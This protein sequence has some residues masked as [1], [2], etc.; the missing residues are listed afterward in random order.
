[1][2]IRHTVS[3][4][5]ILLAAVL[6]AVLLSSCTDDGRETGSENMV[7]LYRDTVAYDHTGQFVSIK[8]SVD[9]SISLGYDGTEAG[10]AEVS[11]DEGSGDRNNVML[12]YSENMD[13]VSR[14]VSLNVAFSDG[15]QITVTLVQSGSPG[16]PG[17]DSGSGSEPDP[18]RDLES[19]P[20]QSGWMELP[21]VVENDDCTFYSH[22]MTVSGRTVRNYSFLYDRDNLLSHW[23]AYPLNSGL[24]GS[25]GRTGEWGYDPLVPRNEQPVLFSGYRGNYDRGHQQPSADRLNYNANVQTFY[26]TNMTPQF[27]RNFNQSIWAGL[28]DQVRNVA[29]S[30]DTLYVV[31]G[32][33][34]DGSLGVA[35]DNEGKEVTVPGAYFKALLRYSASSGT[36]YGGYAAA[37]F[38]LE[39]RSYGSTVITEDM[40]KSIDELEE[41]T[42]LDFFVNLPDK[43]GPTLAAQVEAQN[44]DNVGIWWN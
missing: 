3:R 17:D 34:L 27:G 36:G 6:P 16:V 21:A 10:W 15:E 24:I 44:P 29:R 26:F 25:G 40:C 18:W 30:S 23:V 9:W 43:I 42:G 11:P 32:C 12:I 7:M 28:E 33:V 35:Y 14:K 38:W 2:Y 39:H 4:I 5:V 31:T 13:T 19:D 22:D 41:L 37:G 8:S 20:Y 1:M